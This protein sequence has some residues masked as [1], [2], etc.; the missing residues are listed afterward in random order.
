MVD[1]PAGR[2]A[3]RFIMEWYTYV[4]MSSKTGALYKGL[5]ENLDRRLKEHFNGNVTSTKSILPLKLVHV[6]LSSSRKEAR[7]LEVFFKTGYGREIL[8]EIVND[9][10]S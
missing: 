1:L 3:R 2:Q 8:K 7:D 9:R 10:E 6:E 5:T 4:L